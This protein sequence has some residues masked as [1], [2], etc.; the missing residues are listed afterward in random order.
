MSS[1]R[2]AKDLLELDDI[3][4]AEVFA[5]IKKAAYQREELEDF[6]LLERRDMIAATDTEKLTKILS[7][8][9]TDPD[10]MSSAWWKTQAKEAFLKKDAEFQQRRLMETAITANAIYLQMEREN[11]LNTDSYD[12][13]IMEVITDLAREFEYTFFETDEY[14]D[15]Y[16]SLLEKWLPARLKEEL[17]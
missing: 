2:V 10:C 4:F 12:G 8:I 5:W 17:E 14:E 7:E 11:K 9:I 1:I 6:Q 3:E 16:I 15:D 13:D